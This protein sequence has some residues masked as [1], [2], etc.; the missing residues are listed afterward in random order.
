MKNFRRYT[1]M[2]Q[3]INNVHHS[4]RREA[5][6]RPWCL[7]LLH[8]EKDHMFFVGYFSRR[9]QQRHLTSPA[10]TKS[11][12]ASNSYD[13]A[14]VRNV[15]SVHET[16]HGFILFQISLSDW[17][18]NCSKITRKQRHAYVTKKWS[19]INNA[20]WC[21]FLQIVVSCVISFLS[22]LPAEPSYRHEYRYYTAL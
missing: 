18:L 12:C 1:Y 16:W 8:H 20:N 6:E 17:T 13:G 11:E 19:R 15:E 14:T 21:E 22:I 7:L 2:V 3:T 9:V 4:I 10:V 5:W